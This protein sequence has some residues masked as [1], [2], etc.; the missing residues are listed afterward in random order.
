MNYEGK[1][2]LPNESL[3]NEEQSKYLQYQYIIITITMIPIT[4][5]II[6]IIIIKKKKIIPTNI[7]ITII[8]TLKIITKL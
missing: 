1:S 2:R 3:N 7:T 8:T 6:I 4:I 5:K